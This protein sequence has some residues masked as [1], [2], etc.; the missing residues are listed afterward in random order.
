MRQLVI[1]LIQPE[2]RRGFQGLGRRGNW[3]LVLT[4]YRVPFLLGEREFSREFPRQCSRLGLQA[5]T[6]KGAS[7]IPDWGTKS[8]Q[9][10]QRGLNKQSRVLFCFKSFT[11]RWQCQLHDNG[12]GLRATEPG[13]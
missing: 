7:L 10:L 13:T 9:G 2:S 12:R 6:A 5:F 1:K 4:G 8:L 3:E 11:G